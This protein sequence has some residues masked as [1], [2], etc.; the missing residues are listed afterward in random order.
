MWLT[1]PYM[2]RNHVFRRIF[3]SII[4]LNHIFCL[5]ISI[6]MD[7][8]PLSEKVRLTLQIIANDTP[9]PLPVRRYGRI[10]RESSS[11]IPGFSIRKP[12]WKSLTFVKSNDTPRLR[13]GQFLLDR[14]GWRHLAGVVGAH[15]DGVASVPWIAG[16][17][18][19]GYTYS[20]GHGCYNWWFLWDEKHSIHGVSG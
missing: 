11:F 2:S 12:F 3:L 17:D 13:G 4:N 18:F 20:Y 5:G 10:H 7:P 9:V 19:P 6:P 14:C 15:H 16:H 8:W 1:C